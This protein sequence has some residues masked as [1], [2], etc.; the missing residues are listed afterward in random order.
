MGRGE[1]I[2]SVVLI[3]FGLLVAV[4]SRQYLKLGVMI[5]PDAGFL[6]YCIG[7]ALALLGAIWFVATLAAGP[8]GKEDAT[9]D[10]ADAA[11]GSGAM[12]RNAR[13][14]RLLPGILL[15]LAYAW[16]FERVGYLVSTVLF[17]VAWQRIIERERWKKT[18]LVAALSAGGMYTLFVY[19]LR[20]YLPT[21]SWF[22]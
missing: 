3:V 10:S 21:G 20:V 6:P 4:Y 1:R 8:P 22:S 7:I 16:L 2:C 9:P 11:S 12:V 19:L 13:L 5:S 17:M 15:V 14:A 18:A